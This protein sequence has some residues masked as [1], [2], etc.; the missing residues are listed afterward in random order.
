MGGCVKTHSICVKSPTTRTLN[1]PYEAWGDKKPN[2]GNIKIFGCVAVMKVPSVHT[3]S[4][5]DR[6]R[7]IV[8]LGR[9]P[10]TKGCRLYDPF[11]KKI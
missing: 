9:E 3:R 4:M 2:F 11:T 8:Y 10:G 6:G 7:K 5:D 1:G